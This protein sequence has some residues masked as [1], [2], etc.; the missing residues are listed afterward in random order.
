MFLSVPGFLHVFDTC[1]PMQLKKNSYFASSFLILPK[2][3]TYY[4]SIF[5]PSKTSTR[6]EILVVYILKERLLAKT[7]GFASLVNKE[8]PHI[9]ETHCFLDRHALASKTLSSALKEILSTSVKV[10]NFF[11]A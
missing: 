3:Q 7:L 4:R 2:L 5:L 10:V 1:K 11:R 9:I 8:V 6:R